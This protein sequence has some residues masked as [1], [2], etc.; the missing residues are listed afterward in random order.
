[1]PPILKFIFTRLFSLI[2]T[3]IIITIVLYGLIMLTPVEVRASLY[4][5]KNFRQGMTEEEKQHIIEQIIINRHLRD[6]FP[7]QYLSWIRNLAQGDWGY[8]YTLGDEVLPN[9]LRATPVT[10]E[11][12]F[13]SLILFIPLG[14]VSGAV[15][16]SRASQKIDD[17]LRLAAF[18]A[19][20]LP[21]FILAL[22][23]LS[24]FYVGLYWFPP[25]RLSTEISQEVRSPSFK[26]YTGF[27]TLDGFLNGRPDV[28]GDAAR[29]L[30]L[31]VIT[32]SLLHWA[33]LSRVTRATMIEEL[34]KEYITAARGRGI[35]HRRVVWRHAFRNVLAPSLTSIALSAASLFTGVFMVE[36]IFNFHG[37]SGVIVRGVSSV[38]DVPAVMGFAIYSVIIVLF[39]M[40]V[41]DILTAWLNPL[42]RI[43][44][45]NE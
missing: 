39:V 38:P 41:L 27:I 30:V 36:V 17:T 22:V 37:L 2:T 33:T 23:L 13:Y 45:L 9:L 10:A 1:M 26:T 40:L 44:E 12:T 43:G 29:H 24:I 34:K 4:F 8:S 15:S 16:A 35:T 25:E 6:P 32:L 18:T 19:T 28:S 3:L 20:Y 42:I 7:V 14:L 5:P 21:P 11:L 31:P